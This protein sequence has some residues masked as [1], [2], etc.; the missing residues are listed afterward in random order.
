MTVDDWSLHGLGRIPDQPDERDWRIARFLPARSATRVPARVDYRGRTGPVLDQG[1]SPRCVAYASAAMKTF[2]ERRDRRRTLSFDPIA[3]YD[4]CKGRDGN[5]D[6][7]T[8]GRTA[9]DVLRDRGYPLLHPRPT[10]RDAPEHFAIGGYARI[11]TIPELEQAIAL[12]GPV[13][14]GLLWDASWFRP[15]GARLDTPNDPRIAGG[16][17]ICLIGYDRVR[18]VARFV[19]SWGPA[20]GDRGHG[21]ITYREIDRQLRLP[22][23]YQADLWSTV[24][25]TGD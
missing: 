10:P 19:N 23:G 25:L 5:S 13:L 8:Y 9:C 18:E 2:Q 3:F 24:D 22:N 7:G 14:L 6:A 17:E 20:W 1:P 4:W 16:H 12:N 11:A 21:E 15:D